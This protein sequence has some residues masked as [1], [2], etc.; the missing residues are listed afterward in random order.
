M[1]N[2]WFPLGN[3]S[4][5]MVDFQ[6]CFCRFTVEYEPQRLNLQ[7]LKHDFNHDPYIEPQFSRISIYVCICTH[8]SYIYIM[9][10]Y[11]YICIYI[12]IFQPWWN[13]N[14]D[15]FFLFKQHITSTS[16]CQGKS[17]A[18]VTYVSDHDFNALTKPPRS[19]RADMGFI[20]YIPMY[21]VTKCIYIYIEYEMG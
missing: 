13:S 3:W 21:E 15:Q 6:H 17:V 11:I 18:S 7:I 1:E 9:Y 10:I 12:Y 4:T 19:R 8:V 14:H 16:Q 2:Q 5:F 20:Q